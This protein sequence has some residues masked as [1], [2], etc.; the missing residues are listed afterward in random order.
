MNFRHDINV[1][2]AIAILSVVLYHFKIPFF[3]AGF[4]GVDIFFVI[5]GF[6]LFKIIYEK[7]INDNFSIFSFYLDRAYR[8]IPALGALLLFLMVTLHFFF[9]F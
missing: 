4:I 8:I 7:Y 3:N 9:F 1:L 5:S 2:R 6:L